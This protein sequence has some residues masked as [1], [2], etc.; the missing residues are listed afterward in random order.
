MLGSFGRKAW[1]SDFLDSRY[2]KPGVP[3]SSVA[4]QLPLPTLSPFSQASQCTSS[5]QTKG[6]EPV[7]GGTPPLPLPLLA[8][9]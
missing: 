1:C 4:V 2:L 5:P 8:S 3:L 9:G 6:G 7:H